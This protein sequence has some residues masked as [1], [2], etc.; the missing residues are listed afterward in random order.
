MIFSKNVIVKAFVE[1]SDSGIAELAKDTLHE[2]CINNFGKARIYF[3]NRDQIVCSNNFLDFW[4]CNQQFV[5]EG[6]TNSSTKDEFHFDND[7]SPR[8][9]LE[10]LNFSLGINSPIKLKH[11][12]NLSGGME[13]QVSRWTFGDNKVS[14]KRSSLDSP[15][16]INRLMS[17]CSFGD[18][19]QLDLKLM[20]MVPSKV[21]LVSN[22][23]NFFDSSKEVF[24]L[25]S[26][27]GNLNKILFMKNLQKALIEF[28][29]VESAQLCIDHINKKQIDTLTLRISFSKYQKID[30]KKS[31][32]SENS[33]QF[34]DVYVVLNEQNRFTDL[35][36][37][38]SPPSQS[39]MVLIEKRPD[40]NYTDSCLLIKEAV[41]RLEVQTFGEKID[42]Q[43]SKCIRMT[44]GVQ[45]I[46]NAIL[47]VTK[48]HGSYV[49]SSSLDVNFC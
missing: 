9:N 12:F 38:F 6:L 49:K 23:E 22:L 31:N 43:H 34:N 27:F 37:R 45:S 24:N 47:V 8:D 29:S 13:S 2:T 44:F 48:L 15:T 14:V 4:D 25:F 11:E 3:S 41:S 18:G 21:V 7:P 42:Y 19:K 20:P 16:S 46:H 26:C 30:L 33:Q 36:V 17:E 40:L 35:S 32:K 28:A 39:V 5:K 10:M 1:F